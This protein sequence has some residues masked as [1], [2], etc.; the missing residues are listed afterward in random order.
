M[1]RFAALNIGAGKNFEVAKLSPEMKKAIAHGMADAWEALAEARKQVDTGRVTAGDFLGMR[2]RLKSNY[3][4][5]MLAA[6]LIIYVT[7]KRKRCIRF[8]PWM[9]LAE[10]WTRPR[11][12]TLCA[13]RQ[14]N[15][16]L[17]TRS[18]R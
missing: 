15:Y 10:S 9:K 16:R 5:R 6:V 2:E 1:A 8:I 14:A 11:T 12:V 4:Y 18:G 3:L 7:P 13:S 17:S